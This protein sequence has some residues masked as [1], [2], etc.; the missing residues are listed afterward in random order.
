[1]LAKQIATADMLCDG[2]LDGRPGHR[3]A[4]GGLP[5]SGRG[6]RD[7]QE[8]RNCG[9]GWRSCAA[10][11]QAKRSWTWPIAVSGR[12]RVQPGGPKLLAGA[13]GPKAIALASRWADGLCG[14]SF[15]PDPQ[16]IAATFDL[17]RKAWADAGRPRPHLG[18]SFWFA[19]DDGGR[20]AAR[21]PLEALFHL[22]RSGGARCDCGQCGFCGFAAGIEGHAAAD[23]G[24]GRGR[25]AAY[26]DP[27]RTSIR[28]T[29]SPM[30][31]G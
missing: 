15:G 28:F 10:S 8:R 26:P 30:S 16:E 31:I 3:R 4:R 12:H 22:G 18:T 5:G 24:C 6:F 20:G 13:M 27:I 17:A 23:R 14:M 29:A 19:L 9:A 25:G 1:M 2:R 11:G 7:A 21:S